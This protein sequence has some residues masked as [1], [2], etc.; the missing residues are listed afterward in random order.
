MSSANIGLYGCFIVDLLSEKAEKK[1]AWSA[2]QQFEG[3]CMVISMLTIYALIANSSY[4]FVDLLKQCRS[5]N[6][7]ADKAILDAKQALWGASKNDV[8]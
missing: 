4:F 8:S 6:E 2:E 3:I 1:V 5:L 7:E